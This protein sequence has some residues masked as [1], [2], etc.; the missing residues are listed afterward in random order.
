MPQGERGHVAYKKEATWGIPVGVANKILHTTSEGIIQNIEEILSKAS[1]GI[2]DEPHSHKGLHTFGGPIA[3]EVHPLN[4][5]D[6][7]RSAIATPVPTAAGVA[8]VL[9]HNCNHAWNALGT[10]FC[11]RDTID[12]K[13]GDASV[14]IIMPEDV[15]AGNKVAT[16]DFQVVGTDIAFIDGGVGEEDTITTVDGNFL[17]AAFAAGKDIVVTGSGSND[18]TYTILSVTEKVINVGTGLLTAEGAGA[19]V[20]IKSVIDMEADDEVIFW[21]KCSI[22]TLLGNF[23]FLIDE[24]AACAAPEMDI[25]IPGGTANVWQEVTLTLGDM[26][27]LNDILSIGLEM[28][29]DIAECTVWI[30]KIRRI[31]NDL[32]A[33]T[34]KDHTFTPLQTDFHADCPLDPYTIEV[35]RDQ[36]VAEAWQ[37]EGCVVNTLNLRFGV[38]DKILNGVA[39]ILAREANRITREIIPFP[40]TAPF[41]WSQALIQLGN[42]LPTNNYLES[43]E[44][45]V[46]NKIIG[47]PSLNQSSF[48]RRFY[49]SGP[50]VIT[51]NFVTD[52][53]DQVEYDI[54]VAGDEQKLKIIFT[55]AAVVGDAG[56]SYTLTIYMPKFRYL[57]YPIT[58]PGEG[59]ISVGVT[60]K[61]KY[62]ETVDY[63]IQFILRN[64][65]ADY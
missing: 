23:K 49:R 42:A 4:F 20:T 57:T 7:L 56:Y 14:K 29:D 31:D 8:I 40:T 55:G 9:L 48:I 27:G 46:D 18:D 1:R 44:I 39:E 25:D 36:N 50:R 2:L 15:T 5:G 41:T 17:A 32:T 63:A 64:E 45:N 60:G 11:E 52:F 13:E 62:C 16:I 12:K 37:F 28:E 22:D 34:A 10:C 30:D 33:T 53:V 47:I 21:I 61:A 59:R 24:Q 58:N 6:I 51:C 35:H 19:G 65:L 43:V 38:D 26:T 3:F 54:F